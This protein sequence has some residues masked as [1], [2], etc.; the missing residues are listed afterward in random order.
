VLIVED[1]AAICSALRDVLK[2]E[3]LPAR[4]AGNG[5]EA[6]ELIAAQGPPHLILLDLMMPEMDG[7]TFLQHQRA[8]PTLARIPVVI[9][10]ASQ[11]GD[12][13]H[14]AASALLK[15]PFTIHQLLLTLEPWISRQAG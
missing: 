3:G 10:T 9:M 4:S 6:L 8:N 14:L 12:L 11:R 15:K 7:A 1:D 13:G 5:R 2:G